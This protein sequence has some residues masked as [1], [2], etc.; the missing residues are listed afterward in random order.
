M[1]GSLATTVTVLLVVLLLVGVLKSLLDSTSVLLEESLLRTDWDRSRD[2]L[3]TV[4][5]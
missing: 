1:E 5:L 2:R 4:C 3:A